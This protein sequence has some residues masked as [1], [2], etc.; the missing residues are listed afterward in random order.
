MLTL[1]I[2]LLAPEFDEL[3]SGVQRQRELLERQAKALMAPLRALWEQHTAA[4]LAGCEGWARRGALAATALS[5]IRE[6]M[7]VLQDFEG[8]EEHLTAL[9][10]E[11]HQAAASIAPQ[12]LSGPLA[13]AALA[14]GGAGDGAQ[15]QR[16]HALGKNWERLLQVALVTM[17]RWV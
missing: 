1:P 6:L 5:A 7:H 9:L 17:D 11:V 4:L 2:P 14:D 16:W 13:A 8:I 10:T 3:A 15:A 12:L